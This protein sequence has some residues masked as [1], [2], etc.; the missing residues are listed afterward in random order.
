MSKKKIISLA[1]GVIIVA[2]IA[3]WAFGGQAKKRKVVYAVSY[4]HLDVYKRQ[5]SLL[6][7]MQAIMTCHTSQEKLKGYPAILPTLSFLFL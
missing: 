2:G 5:C 3:I 6:L 7:S 1:V 4:T